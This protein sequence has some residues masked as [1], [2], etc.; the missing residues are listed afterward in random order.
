MNTVF[1]SVALLGCQAINFFTVK[2][3]CASIDRLG[4]RITT[5]E[6]RQ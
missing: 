6:S 4:A 5:L 2:S 3:M 1:L